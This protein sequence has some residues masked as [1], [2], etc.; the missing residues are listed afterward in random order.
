MC[1]VNYLGDS[2]DSEP[3]FQS[4]KNL[5]HRLTARNLFFKRISLSP[6]CST[7]SLKFLDS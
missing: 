2:T 7:V 5:N 1:E 6:C 4:S 3:E